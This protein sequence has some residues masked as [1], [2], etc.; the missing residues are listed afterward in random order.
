MKFLMPYGIHTPPMREV[1]KWKL[2]TLFKKR[3]PV[4]AD[5][6]FRLEV[7]SLTAEDLEREEDFIV[8][9]GHATFYMQLDGVKIITDPVFG[10]IP[11]IRRLVDFPIDSKYLNPDIVL[12][13]HGHYDHLDT[14][15]LAAMQI[16]RKKCKVILPLNLSSYLKKGAD[17]TELD[18]YESFQYHE[19]VTVTAVPASHWHR[20]GLFDFNRALWCSF[21][22]EY[23]DKTIFFAGDTAFDRHFDE[24]AQKIAPPDIALLPIGAYKPVEVMRQNHLNPEEAVEAAKI[25]G[26][27]MMIPYHYGTFKLSDEPVGEPHSWI[28]RLAEE[29]RQEIRILGVG[30]VLPLVWQKT[31]KKDMT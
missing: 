22:L 24:I 17:V 3:R 23:K 28:S 5:D 19:K 14:D 30:E 21:V 26:A 27:G 4:V 12:I 10:N 16:Y 1:F 20:R 7:H 18:W 13:S 15:S 8:W 6:D 31:D 9:M 29:G 2:R 11:M 25:V